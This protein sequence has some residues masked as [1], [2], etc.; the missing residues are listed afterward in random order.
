MVTAEI[1]MDVGY[2]CTGN[3]NIPNMNESN[4]NL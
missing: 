4:E 2:R 1:K 3:D